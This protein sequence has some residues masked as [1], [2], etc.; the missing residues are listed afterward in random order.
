MDETRYFH[1]PGCSKSKAALA[2]LH[3]RGVEPRVVHYLDGAPDLAE[4]ILLANLLGGDPRAMMRLDEPEAVALDLGNPGKTLDDLL[5]AIQR[6]P[7][8]L[9]RPIFVHRGRAIIG[10]PIERVL[11]LL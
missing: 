5:A 10:R 4:L 6:H 1:N 11:E 8:L 3:E 2:L 9:Q 7:M